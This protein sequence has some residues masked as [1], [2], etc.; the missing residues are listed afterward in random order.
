MYKTPLRIQCTNF[1][2]KEIKIE[3]I[4]AF[5]TVCT[6]LPNCTKQFEQCCIED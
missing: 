4:N 3:E 5:G 1:D 6:M 2:P